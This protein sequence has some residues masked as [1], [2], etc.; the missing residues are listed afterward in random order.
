MIDVR[1][2]SQIKSWQN[3]TGSRYV[4]FYPGLVHFVYVNRVSNL[5]VAPSF[6]LGGQLKNKAKSKGTNVKG[7]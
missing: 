4:Y 1:L 5:V 7:E 3:T 2:F 6:D